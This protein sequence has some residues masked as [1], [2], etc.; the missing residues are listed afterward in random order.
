MPAFSWRSTLPHPPAAVER[1][2]RAPDASGRLLPPWERTDPAGRLAVGPCRLRFTVD[3][4]AL[5]LRIPAIPLVSERRIAPIPTGSAVEDRARWLPRFG[6]VDD[7]LRRR[8]SRAIRWQHHKLDRDLRRSLPGDRRALQIAISGASGLVGSALSAFLHGIGHRVIPLVRDDRPGIRWDPRGGTVGP[9]LEDVDAVIHLA[10]APIAPRRWSPAVREQ[11]RASRVC[12]TRTLARALARLPPKVFI[13]TSAVGYYGDRG[14]RTLCEEDGP[15]TGFLAE[16][17]R[18]WEEAVEPAR[19]AGW[20]VTTVRVGLVLSARG[21]LLRALLPL[22]RLGLGGRIGDGSQ[23][24][25]W[26][27]LDDLVGLY[28]WLLH[29]PLEGPVNGTAPTPV[30]NRTF[31]ATLARSLHRPAFLPAPAPLLHLAAG[32]TKADELLL[33]SQRAPPVRA[34]RAGFRFF[35]PTLDEALALELATAWDRG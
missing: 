35:A 10:G 8:L 16:V 9:G 28:H 11:I 21:G 33:A 14:D 20:R 15:G 1:W 6:P 26:I 5:H 34:L 23:W 29:T 18:A 7:A 31:S 22:F 2:H 4:E 3:A 19:D 30:R 24:M 25:S 12:G 27:H 32:P 17:A 13:S